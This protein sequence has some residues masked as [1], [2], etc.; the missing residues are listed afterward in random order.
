ME[1]SEIT[2]E[3]ARSWLLINPTRE[4]LMEQIPGCQADALILDIE[5]A[6][7]PQK[8]DSTREII[9]DWFAHNSTKAWI[10][11]NPVTTPY[12]KEDIE[13]FSPLINNDNFEGVMLAK[14]EDL[15]SLETTH[16]ALSGTK[17]IALVETA[18]GMENI[19][20]ITRARGVSRIAFGI[21]DYRRDTGFAPHSP[22]ID[23]TRTRLT[24]AAKAAGL[25]GVIDGPTMSTRKEQL[26]KDAAL[27]LEFGM[28][29]K[30]CLQPQLCSFINEG[31]SPSAED[32]EWA[33]NFLEEFEE[34]G[35]QIRDGS[36]PPRL[37][38][39]HK[40]LELAELF[41]IERSPVM[42]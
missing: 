8:K 25:P 35:G 36:D 4:D 9:L 18:L 2:P 17:T 32:I 41:H 31:L 12:W 40:L 29:G 38:S 16:Q 34:A 27:T 28:T 10:R 5:D 11:I 20:S 14:T 6:I 3:H 26:I 33:W 7:P 24:I 22:A 21:S 23:Y 37:A 15:H 39:A 42:C 19:S 1:H 13:A 30:L